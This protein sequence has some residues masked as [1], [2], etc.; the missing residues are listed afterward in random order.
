MNKYLIILIL[1]VIFFTL[2]I[3]I[4]FNYINKKDTPDDVWES[5]LVEDE[6]I[7]KSIKQGE[8][9]P[10]HITIE[11]YG[12][13][14]NLKNQF[15]EELV[16]PYSKENG[17]I[18]S[19]YF[20]TEY[21]SKNE[22]RPLILDVIKNGYSVFGKKMLSIYDK[23]GLSGISL[24]DLAKL[25]KLA[26]YNY[27]SIS[28]APPDS[29]DLYSKAYFTYSAP[30]VSSALYKYNTNYKPDEFK[31]ILTN[32]DLPEHSLTPKVGKYTNEID[33]EQGKEVSCGFPC[34]INGHDE[35]FTDSNGITR[36]YMCGSV[37]YPTLKTPERYSVYKINV[38]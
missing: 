36:Q 5:S 30:T 3:I 2:V 13:F 7:F 12:C 6:S 35:T 26:G 29:K 1:S 33:N 11:P 27:L 34:T 38:H 28:K 17:K 25:G 21:K 20:F 9:N 10:D 32:S 4:I 19:S 18:N 37:N 15:F 8:L 14:S 16:N 22:I 24:L 31:S 23:N